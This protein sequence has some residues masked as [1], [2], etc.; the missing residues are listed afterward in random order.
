MSVHAPATDA[1]NRNQN[2]QDGKDQNHRTDQKLAE[3][4]SWDP[5]D[6]D[7]GPQVGQTNF[8]KVEVEVENAAKNETRNLSNSRTTK[9]TEP[10]TRVTK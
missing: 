2:Y 6:L 9:I 1:T 5:T 10:V 8:R 4:R 7:H 3:I